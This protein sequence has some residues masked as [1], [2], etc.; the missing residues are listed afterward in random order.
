M[1]I[2]NSNSDV[3]LLVLVRP[4]DSLYALL[5]SVLRQGGCE[6]SVYATIYD[7]IN[8]IREI[9][10]G[11]PMILVARPAML[12]PQAA[13]FLERHFPNL[14]IIGWI[15]AGENVSDPAIARTT[16][17]GMMTAGHLEQLRQMVRSICETVSRSQSVPEARRVDSPDK[18]KEL[19]YDLSDDEINA[20]LG[21]E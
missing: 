13:S 12:G 19:E 9:P 11:C 6:F 3:R 8:G 1:R 21:V 14:R 10:A 15:D 16:A 4:A 20:L 5:A 17:N 7:L 18:F 2:E